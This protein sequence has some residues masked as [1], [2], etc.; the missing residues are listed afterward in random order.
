MLFVKKYYQVDWDDLF[1]GKDAVDC[2]TLFYGYLTQLIENYVP[3]T[4]RQTKSRCLWLD[5]N[6]RRA[7][8]TRNKRL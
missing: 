1:S 8:K 4:N 3:R 6:L 2:Y 7:I 5:R